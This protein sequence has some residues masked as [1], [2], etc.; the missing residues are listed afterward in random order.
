MPTHAVPVFGWTYAAPTG[1]VPY[2]APT[3]IVSSVTVG[4][5][6]SGLVDACAGAATNAVAPSARTQRARF[7]PSP[8]S[9]G[10]G[11]PGR[12]ATST[13]AVAAPPAEVRVVT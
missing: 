1:C 12:S 8:D 6:V 9:E 10:R 3:P 2:I 4:V 11:L 13:A 7:M 5:T